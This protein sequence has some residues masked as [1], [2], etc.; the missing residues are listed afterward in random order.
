MLAA[1]APP[2]RITWRPEVVVSVDAIWKMKTAFALPWASSVKSP[3]EISS[4]E[5]DL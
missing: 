2:I 3:E 1:L 4:E 5:V